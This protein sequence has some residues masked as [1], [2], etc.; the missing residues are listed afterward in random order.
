[1]NHY[2]HSVEQD[3]AGKWYARVALSDEQA[4]FLKFQSYPTMAEIQDAAN[5]YVADP[6]P[7]EEVNNAP[8][9]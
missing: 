5:A 8:A 4:V 7:E 1:M 9:E 3:L 6:Q 2:V